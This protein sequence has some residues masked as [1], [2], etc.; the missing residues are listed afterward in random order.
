MAAANAELH[1][2]QNAA[3]GARLMPG[4]SFTGRAATGVEIA[5]MEDPARGRQPLG[6]RD[7]VILLAGPSI[8]K[9]FIRIESI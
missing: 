6:R 5:F 4:A 1:R 8:D 7:E 9:L 3:M 2:K